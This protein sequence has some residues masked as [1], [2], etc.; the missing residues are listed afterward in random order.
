LVEAG[1]DSERVYELAR[2]GDRTYAGVLDAIMR[3]F[4]QRHG[5][6]RWCEKT[7]LQ[8]APLLWEQFPSAQLVHIVRDPRD[9]IAS[10]SKLPWETP[11]AVTLARKWRDFTAEAI[12]AGAVRGPS[13]YLRIRYEDLARDP[14]AVLTQVFSFLGED[15]DAAVVTDS[16]RRRSTVMPAATGWLGKVLGPITPPEEGA[17]RDNLPRSAQ[18]R[19]APIVNPLLGGLGYPASARTESIGGWALNAVTAPVAAGRRLSARVSRRVRS[20][21]AST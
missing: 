1:F 18:V 6:A 8:G 16:D 20:G 17:W 3:D 21:P 12:R 11:D 7:P 14:V 2:A 10:H 19:I 9:S 15:F 13:A 4:A 5:K